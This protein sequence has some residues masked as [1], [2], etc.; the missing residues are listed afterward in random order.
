MLYKLE[1]INHRHGG[2]TEIMLPGRRIV[3]DECNGTGR[4]LCDSL[5]G[6]AFS[7]DEMEPD[8][9]DAYFRGDYDVQCD[10]CHGNNVILVPDEDQLTKRQR[11]LWQS[12][13][14]RE[15]EYQAELAHERRMRERGIQ[16]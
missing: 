10:V 2:I 16:W 3:C 5:R 12:H 9:E 1:Y 13:T 6:V 7:R 15:A 11:I 4:V 14:A 8:F